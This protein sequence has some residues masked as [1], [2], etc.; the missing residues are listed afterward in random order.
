M[1]TV[2]YRICAVRN[3]KY[4]TLFH[5]NQGSRE[6]PIDVWLKAEKKVVTDGNPLHSMP[7][8]SG[9]HIMTSKEAALQYLG[10]KF[11]NFAEKAVVA[12]IARGIRK[13]QHSRNEV[14]LADYMKLIA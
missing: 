13:K 4:Y 11:K 5:G 14:F 2:F 1:S 8:V 6:L 9:F 10:R 3:G 12:C 7:Y